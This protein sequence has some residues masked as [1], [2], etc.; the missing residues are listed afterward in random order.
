PRWKVAEEVGPPSGET[1]AEVVSKLLAGILQA[2]HEQEQY[3]A[4]L[5]SEVDH[6]FREV[7]G[8]QSAIAKGESSQ[9]IKRDGG[10]AKA[11]G[12]PGQERQSKNGG[13]QLDEDP[14]HRGVTSTE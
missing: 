8:D 14:A 5:G 2:E 9:Q 10:K 6:P 4:D 3:H 7:K 11:M 1:A 12:E 13:P